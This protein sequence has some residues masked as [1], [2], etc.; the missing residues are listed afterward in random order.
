[1]TLLERVPE[2]ASSG[3]PEP[4]G[5]GRESGPSA[6]QEKKNARVTGVHCH[7]HHGR[8]RNQKKN[9]RKLSHGPNFPK[10][11]LTVSPVPNSPLQR[12]KNTSA[13]LLNPMGSIARCPRGRNE[14]AAAPRAP[15][16]AI[17]LPPKT[18]DATADE[19]CRRMVR[20]PPAARC[21]LLLPRR[22]RGPSA[23]RPSA[24]ATGTALGSGTPWGLSRTKA[25]GGRRLAD[26]ASVARFPAARIPDA[27]RRKQPLEG[28]N[29]EAAAG[30][31]AAENNVLGRGDGQK[32]S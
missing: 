1:M 6:E 21:R 2:G 32:E 19:L 12:G 8:R 22:A 20:T 9:S 7:S 11:E 25:Q 31:E 10:K 13:S 16:E 27:R 30:S 14:L 29:W 24:R 3:R 18:R 17:L 28:G 4:T 15:L 5:G 26:K 23:L